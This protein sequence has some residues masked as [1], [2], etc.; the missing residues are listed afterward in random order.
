LFIAI[1]ILAKK[2]GDPQM[3]LSE[4]EFRWMH[5]ED[6]MA[7]DKLNEGIRKFAAD[8]KKLEELIRKELN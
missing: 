5:N 3:S 6:E 1:L 2:I 4:K 8:S 7:T